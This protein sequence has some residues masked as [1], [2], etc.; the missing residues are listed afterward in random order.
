[1]RRYVLVFL[2]LVLPLQWSWAA[3][4]ST[5]LHEPGDVQH[6]GH[7]AQE[8]VHASADL[9][10]DDADGADGACLD[11]DCASCHGPGLAALIS[12]PAPVGACPG[13]IA[14]SG[15][16]RHLPEPQPDNPLRPPLSNPV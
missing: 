1:M 15:Y 5:C 2:M 9:H 12:L 10:G 11:S 3:V 7:H 14:T 8:H 6:L 13:G 16:L 4:V